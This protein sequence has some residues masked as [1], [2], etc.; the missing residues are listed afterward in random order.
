MKH[1]ED[2]ILTTHVGSLPRNPVLSELLIIILYVVTWDSGGNAISAQE[3]IY[4]RVFEPIEG[5][6]FS[7]FLFA[8][9]YV[10][11]CWLICRWLYVRQIFIKI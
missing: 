6:A 8:L 5:A 3:W 2:R 1:S 10:A 11:L 4:T 7:S 9:S